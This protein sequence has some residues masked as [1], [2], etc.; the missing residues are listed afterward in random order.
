L[1]EFK[2]G[3]AEFKS[4]FGRA[5]GGEGWRRGALFMAVDAAWKVRGGSEGWG[6]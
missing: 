2:C 6:I 4:S 5:G 3:L 1:V